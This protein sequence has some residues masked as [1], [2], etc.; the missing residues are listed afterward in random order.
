MRHYDL[1]PVNLIDGNQ[2]FNASIYQD[3]T[4]FMMAYRAAEGIGNCRL[5]LHP[6]K[7]KDNQYSFTDD[8]SMILSI[9]AIRKNDRMVCEDPRVF[10]FQDRMWVAFTYIDVDNECQS[11][12]IAPLHDV[13]G[14]EMLLNPTF[15]NYQDN[16]NGSN[17]PEYVKEGNLVT[18]RLEF[19]VK[20]EKN[21]Q[22]F[23]NRGQLNFIYL[24]NPMHEVVTLNDDMSVQKVHRTR[25]NI[26]WPFGWIRGG[27]PPLVFDS[28]HYITF[29]HSCFRPPQDGWSKHEVYNSCYVMGAYLFERKAPYRIKFITARPLMVGDFNDPNVMSN[30]DRHYSLWGNAV[31]YPCGALFSSRGFDVSMGYNDYKIKIA[32]FGYEE[33]G[34]EFRKIVV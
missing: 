8:K 34:R 3:R 6:L 23:E 11:Q 17:T 5:A 27:T 30:T 21:W 9:P 25:N 10:R 4:G 20:M 7:F 24:A 31:V 1:S 28:D 13:R 22:F 12:G 33:L 14:D 2:Y 29:F 19:P 32:S 16:I 15:I 26:R 18:V